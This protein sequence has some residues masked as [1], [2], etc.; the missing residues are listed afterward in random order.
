ME[1]ATEGEEEEEIEL[2]EKGERELVNGEEE[3]ERLGEGRIGAGRVLGRVLGGED[4]GERGSGGEIKEDSGG[5]VFGE[6][7]D[8]GREGEEEGDEDD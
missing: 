1:Q 7:G 3:E 6:G 5:L 4:K 8:E 2:G